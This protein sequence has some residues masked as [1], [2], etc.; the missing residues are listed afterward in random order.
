MGFWISL[1]GMNIGGFPLKAGKSELVT[2]LAAWPW[3]ETVD[4]RLPGL[5]SCPPRA[6][7]PSTQASS[8]P[9]AL[10]MPA[11]SRSKH[12]PLHSSLAQSL[13]V[14]PR[15]W[16]PPPIPPSISVPLLGLS[17]HHPT[18]QDTSLCLYAYCLLLSLGPE[19]HEGLGSYSLLYP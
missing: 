4:L 16:S 6:F 12:I 15:Q 14:S 8:G 9:L 17:C 19:P 7:R 11:L 3:A 2:N 13:L 18:R 10:A 5:T 1:L